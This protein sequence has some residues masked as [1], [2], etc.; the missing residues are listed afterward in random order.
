MD[1]RRCGGTQYV[2]DDH[3]QV[4]EVSGLMKGAA[5]RIT[6]RAAGMVCGGGQSVGRHRRKRIGADITT[7]G[8][9]NKSGG[10]SAGAQERARSDQRQRSSG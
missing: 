8:A 5:G 10:D 2:L 4:E 7:A 3:F 9:G 6:W 1:R